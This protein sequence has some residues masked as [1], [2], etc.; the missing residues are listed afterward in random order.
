MGDTFLKMKK[1]AEESRRTGKGIA[2]LSTR[3]V[4]NTNCRSKWKQYSSPQTCTAEIG[5]KKL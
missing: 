4:Y 1:E 3:V 5:S 2:L